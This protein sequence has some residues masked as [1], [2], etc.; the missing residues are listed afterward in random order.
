MNCDKI[1]N[2]CLHILEAYT[3][4]YRVSSSDKVRQ[5]LKDVLLINL[6]K[7]V[8]NN[9]YKFNLYFDEDWKPLSAVNS[10]GHDI[11]REAGFYARLSGCLMMKN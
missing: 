4:L 2:T 9:S 3:N 8:D 5:S 1:M 11:E 7:V 10:F 6:D